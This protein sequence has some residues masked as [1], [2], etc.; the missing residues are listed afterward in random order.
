M[1]TLSRTSIQ[2]MVG[3]NEGIG[4]AG[5]GTGG[6]GGGVDLSGLMPITT[7]FWGQSV[8]DGAVEGSIE[9]GTNGGTLGGFH[10]LELNTHG[11]LSGYGGYIDFHYNGSSADYTSRIMEDSSGVLNLNGQVLITSG[12][13]VGIG[14]TS[15]SSYK[16]RVGGSEYLVG[17][18]LYFDNNRAIYFK[19]SNGNMR[20]A[21]TVNSSNQ[22]AVGYEFRLRGY[23][24]DIQ[25]GIITFATNNG[26]SNGVDHRIEAMQIETS[27]RTW[28]KQG[29][30]IGDGVILW[31]S[32]NNALKVQKQDGSVANLYAT[33]GLSALGMTAGVS[34]LDAMT[35]GNLT[36]TEKLTLDDTTGGGKGGGV[37]ETAGD[38][39]DAALHIRTYDN[40]SWV[41]VSD[42]CSEDGVDY[43]KILMDGEA[44]FTKVYSPRFYLDG[45][46]YFFLD[47]GVLKFYN[48]ST[49]KT[50]Q[51]V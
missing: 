11:T 5:G 3:T 21:M 25:G 17:G 8:A 41:M 16:L 19:D 43:W 13:N 31:D 49:A 10:G 1:K 39:P 30:R 37:I 4:N 45:T 6:G 24:T 29:L 38:D 26:Y 12:G 32:A 48:G 2:R 7:T 40:S 33:G 34:S 18:G 50:V 23:T 20:N 14:T 44:R 22:M 36:V 9:A 27:G 47:S 35:F 42:M 46:H 15:D 28:I 51:L